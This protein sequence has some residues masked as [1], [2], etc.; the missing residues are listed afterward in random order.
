MRKKRFADIVKQVAVA[1]HIF[2]PHQPPASK[3]D[4]LNALESLCSTYRSDQYSV[5]LAN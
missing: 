2:D 4:T 5:R 3:G 1:A